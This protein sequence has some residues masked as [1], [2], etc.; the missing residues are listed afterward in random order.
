MEKKKKNIL[1]RSIHF[2]L[3]FRR[4]LPAIARRYKFPPKKTETNWQS[5]KVNNKKIYVYVISFSHPFTIYEILLGG[6]FFFFLETV[7]GKL[8]LWVRVNVALI[9]TRDGWDLNW[10]KAHTF[11]TTHYIIGAPNIGR[12]QIYEIFNEF[13]CI[14]LYSVLLTTCILY[15]QFLLPLICLPQDSRGS[16]SF[17]FT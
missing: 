17:T 6:N 11:T 1:V 4:K 8:K 10:L 5:L 12:T 15:R 7:A 16:T 9:L 2:L 13:S 14:D 3:I